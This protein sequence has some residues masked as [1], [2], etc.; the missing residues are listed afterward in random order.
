[1][2]KTARTHY[3]FLGNVLKKR[4]PLYSRK[5]INVA[6]VQLVHVVRQSWLINVNERASFFTDVYKEHIKRVTSRLCSP[7]STLYVPTYS[8]N[9]IVKSA[10]NLLLNNEQKHPFPD[11]QS[12]RTPSTD[13]E[14]IISSSHYYYYSLVSPRDSRW[15]IPVKFHL[16]QKYFVI[17]T[18]EPLLIPLDSKSS[19]IQPQLR[20]SFLKSVYILQTRRKKNE[21]E[22]EEKGLEKN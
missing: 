14:N 1:M 7:I 16:I 17:E 21:R 11:Y 15:K 10:K 4:A 8:Q 6:W 22:I 13:T 3:P 18:K 12:S 19:V 9:Y 20:I 5:R 2:N